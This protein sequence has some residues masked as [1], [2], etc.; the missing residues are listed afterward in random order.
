VEQSSGWKGKWKGKLSRVLAMAAGGGAWRRAGVL[1]PVLGLS[2][3]VQAIQ[4]GINIALARAVGLGLEPASMAWVVPV[5]ALS[6]VV[7]L[8][9]GGLGAREAG[10]L[11]LL[12]GAFGSGDV[13]AW[14]LLWQAVVWLSSLLGAPAAWRWRQLKATST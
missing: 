4:I 10:A 5:L 12:G 9:I 2:L 6:A 7:P 11:A 8:G 3:G 14:S 13:L 1:G